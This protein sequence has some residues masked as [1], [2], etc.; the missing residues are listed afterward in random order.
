MVI[1][2]PAER[3]GIFS[4]ALLD[5][6]IIDAR[7][8][9]AHQAMLVEFPVLVAIAAKPVSA[10]IVPFIGKADGNAIPIEGPEFLDQPVVELA[11]PLSRQKGF[12]RLAPL[13]EFGAV[14]PPTVGGVGERDT[15]TEARTSVNC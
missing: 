15:R 13:Q 5:R 4:F 1:G 3:P 12:D 8:A 9:K 14:A 11:V 6:N 2:S 7:D 10:V